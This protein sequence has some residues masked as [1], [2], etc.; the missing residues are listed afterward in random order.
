VARCLGGTVPVDPL[1]PGLELEVVTAEELRHPRGGARAAD[2]LQEQG[3]EE[4]R[5]VGGVEA[6]VR[7]EPHADHAASGGVAHGL[8]LRQVDG[9]RE[10]RDDLGLADEG[11]GGVGHD[12]RVIGAAGRPLKNAR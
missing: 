9:T 4:R 6:G 12:S 5:A 7:R 2:V 3:V 10:R 11:A 8:A 1:E